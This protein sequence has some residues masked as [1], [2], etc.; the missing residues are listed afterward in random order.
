M[1]R[2]L[3]TDVSA[4]QSDLDDIGNQLKASDEVSKK[5]MNDAGRLA[6]ELRSEQEHAAHMESLRK[7]IEVQVRELQQRFED[8]EANSNKSGNRMINSIEQK[9][10]ELE[11]VLDN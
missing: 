3:E 1:R 8:A 4:M 6:D 2:K 7:T 9:I 5:A 11:A 10:R